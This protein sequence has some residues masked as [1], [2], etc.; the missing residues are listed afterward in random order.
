[1]FADAATEDFFRARLD[2]MIDLRHPLVVLASRMPWQQI[3]ASVAHLFSRKARAAQAMPDLDRFGEAA[4]PLA[5]KSNAGRPR[6]PLRIMMALLYLKHAFNL[7]DEAVVERG[8]ET[9]RWQYVSGLA[10]DEERRPCDATT[11]VTCRRLLGEEGV[12]ALL[13]QTVNLAVSLKLLPAAALATVVVDATVPETAVAHPTD[14]KRQETGMKPVTAYVDLG[15]RGVDADNPTVAIKHRGTYKT[16]PARERTLLKRRQA[17]EL[18]IGH[19]TG[20]HRMDRCHVKGELGDSLHAGLCAAG[21]NLR[22]LLRMI[23]KK[24]VSFWLRLYWRLC[25]AAPMRANWPR[26]LRDIASITSNR[27][28]PG[29]A[30]ACG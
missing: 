13:A 11:R 6:V 12:E 1:M 25:Q 27:P 9:P 26:M 18:I 7:S 19:L 28:A 22:W 30:A 10:Y 16:L 29:R 21:D 3:E 20:D 23:A 5:R 14:S 2:P 8:C 15:Y 24:G 17:I 4:Q